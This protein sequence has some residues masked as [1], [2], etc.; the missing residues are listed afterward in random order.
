M[1]LC[2]ALMALQG[3]RALDT[4][5]K[6]AGPSG[7]DKGPFVLSRP[8]SRPGL[9]WRNELR[10]CALPQP[11]VCQA[12]GSRTMAITL[13]PSPRCLPE[14]AKSLAREGVGAGPWNLASRPRTTLGSQLHCPS[15]GFLPRCQPPP[16]PDLRMPG[17]QVSGAPLWDQ[18]LGHHPFGWWS[19]ADPCGGLEWRK[20]GQGVRWERS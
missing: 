17:D 3:Q 7:Q 13:S 19:W 10:G 8:A 16:P 14:P 5:H 18:R 11:S 6:A 12:P 9:R 1:R 4:I 15:L 2:L 20:G